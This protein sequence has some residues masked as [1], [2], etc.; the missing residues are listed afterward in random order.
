MYNSSVTFFMNLKT[1]RK[2]KHFFT[3]KKKVTEWVLT[4]FYKLAQRAYLKPT[5]LF[6]CTLNLIWWHL[7]Q[8]NRNTCNKKQI[9]NSL[10]QSQ[11]NLGERTHIT[12]LRTKA[13]NKQHI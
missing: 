2:K 3:G 8:N 10:T 1:D 12:E 13:K 5:N 9:S 7:T 4:H 11:M 6:H